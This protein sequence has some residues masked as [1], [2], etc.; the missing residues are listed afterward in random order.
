MKQKTKQRILLAFLVLAIMATLCACGANSELSMDTASAAGASMNGWD[1][2]VNESFS[3]AMAPEAAM[4]EFYEYDDAG[5]SKSEEAPVGNEKATETAEKYTDKIVY[6][7]NIRTQ[8]TSFDETITQLEKMVDTYGGF[9]QYTD[10]SGQDYYDST[11]NTTKVVDRYAQYTVRIPSDKF[12]SFMDSAQGLGNVLESSKTAE[13]VTSQYTDYEAQLA[14][15]KLQE[16][17]LMEMMEKADK[18]EDLIQLE[19]RLSE[20]RYETDRIE[21]N[22][23]NLQMQ[24]SY[25]TVNISIQ[26]VERY[27]PT[28]PVVRTFSEKISDSFSGGWQDFAEGCEDFAIWF[29]GAIPTLLILLVV[30]ALGFFI[31]R[32]VVKKTALKQKQRLEQR[33]S[34]KKPE[35]SEVKGTPLHPAK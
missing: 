18:V 4:D 15:L 10:I 25:S 32:A 21:R 5:M 22:L 20:V 9:S 2:G 31:L 35:D 3:T 14:S 11:S 26:E 1:A 12:A 24:I 28:A 16:S 33:Q 29:V 8:T 17:R 19:S 27:T 6:T 13:N 23:R 34:E 30:A 7:A